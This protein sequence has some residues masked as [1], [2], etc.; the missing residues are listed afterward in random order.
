MM[1]CWVEDPQSEAFQRHI[2][3]LQDYLWV[4]EDGMKAR[5]G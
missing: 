4:A 1:C 2:P 3:R 5:G